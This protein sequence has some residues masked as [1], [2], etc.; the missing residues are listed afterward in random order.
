MPHVLKKYAVKLMRRIFCL[1][2][3]QV[4]RQTCTERGSHVLVSLVSESLLLR[5]K[6]SSHE[7]AMTTL[8]ADGSSCTFTLSNQS[9]SHCRPDFSTENSSGSN[10][11]NRY[12]SNCLF[13]LSGVSG[14]K[15]GGLFHHHKKK[16]QKC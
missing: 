15:A 3:V 8:G 13:A 10:C 9:K 6:G 4:N 12:S 11:G 14:S 16:K 2:Q 1:K 7:G 5:L